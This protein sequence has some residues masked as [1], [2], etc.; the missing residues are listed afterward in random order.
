MFGADLSPTQGQSKE[1]VA[2]KGLCLGGHTFLTRIASIQ[3][4][5][6]CDAQLRSRGSVSTS[7]IVPNG[8]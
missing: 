6:R 1:R 8:A 4:R 3:G 2:T 7:C 5:Y